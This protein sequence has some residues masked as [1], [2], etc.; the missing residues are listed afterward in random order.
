ML[1]IMGVREWKMRGDIEDNDE[2]SSL[3]CLPKHMRHA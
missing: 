3:I 1:R 2:I